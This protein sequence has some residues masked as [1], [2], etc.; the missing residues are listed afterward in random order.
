LAPRRHRV[1]ATRGATLATTVRVVD[2]V[3]DDATALR[4]DA[5]PA[6]AT[7]LADLGELVLGVAD[8]ADGGAAVDRHAAHLGARHAQGGEITRLGDELDAHAC[9]AGDLAALAGAQLDVVHRGT[10]RDE[11]HRQGATGLD[12]GALT[13]LHAVADAQAT[14]GE[15]VRLG[16]VLV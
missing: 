5:L 9:G 12:V 1:A 14:G 13:A 8:L 16:A 4:A 6:A 3:H 2:R 15:D 7:G 11:A 10:D